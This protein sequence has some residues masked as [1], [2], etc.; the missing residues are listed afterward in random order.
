M[1]GWRTYAT[2]ATCFLLAGA[3]VAGFLPAGVAIDPTSL[4]MTG[5]GLVFARNAVN[6][7]T[8]K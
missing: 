4:V 6:N 3:S 1:T 5:V 8:G 2:A 7:A